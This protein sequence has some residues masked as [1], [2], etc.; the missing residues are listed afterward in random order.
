M[1][2]S[3]LELRGAPV[4]AA[5][6]LLKSSALSLRS[7]QADCAREETVVVLI[8]GAG[9]APSKQLAVG[10][11][12]TR[13]RVVAAGGHAP[14]GLTVAAFISAIFPVVAAMLI[15]VLA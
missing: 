12:P 7:V 3:V 4:L 10:P 5:G 2:S 1:T 13:S 14:A 6:W 15:D 9:A 11:K 8:A